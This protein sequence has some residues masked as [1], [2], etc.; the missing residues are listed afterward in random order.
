M[1]GMG[2]LQTE[3]QKETRTKQTTTKDINKKKEKI[4]ANLLILKL[5][6]F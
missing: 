1:H 2:F 6:F 4:E 5:V 3:K